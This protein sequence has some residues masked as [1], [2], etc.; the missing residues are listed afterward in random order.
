MVSV[1]SKSDLEKMR[2]A[3][4]IVAAALKAV[5]DAVKVGITT[6]ELDEIA[7]KVIR[8]HGA[9]PSFKNYHGFPSAT[10]M[11]V[12]EVVVHGF[13]SHRPLKEGEILSV[14][15]GACYNGFHGDAA[16]TFAI[17]EID[18]AKKRLIEVTEQSFFKGIEFAVVGGRLGDI[19]NAVQVYAESH[20]YSVVRSMTGHGIGRRLHEDPSIPNYGPKGSGLLLK[21]GHTLAIEPM[22][23]MGRYEVEIDRNDGW[24]CR[25]KDGLPAAHY[26]NTIAITDNGPEILTLY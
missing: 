10:C 19:S 26:E 9:T 24:T 14:D 12:D 7:E 16:R 15:V 1:K 11:S 8:S 23:N 17:G 25:T 6:F 18:K 4:Q 20:G 22:I 3:G 13:P 21:A 5:Q 2:V